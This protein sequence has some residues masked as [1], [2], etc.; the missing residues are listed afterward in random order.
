MSF[1]PPP[2]PPPPPP[3]QRQQ[4]SRNQFPPPPPQN[5]RQQ[6]QQQQQQSFQGRPPPPPPPPQQHSQN[7]FLP[8][9]P[10][11]QNL[12]SV[13]SN[14]PPHHSH[15]G[16]YGQQHQQ[17][18]IQT[19]PPPPPAPMIPPPP[20]PPSLP[21][22]AHTNYNQQHQQQQQH[23]HQGNHNINNI[24]QQQQ[25]QQPVYTSQQSAHQYPQ[26]NSHQQQQ[27][28]KQQPPSCPPLF[29]RPQVDGEINIDAPLP[30]YYPKGCWSNDNPDQNE[31]PPAADSRFISLDDGNAAPDFIRSTM[32]RIPSDRHILRSATG[33][34]E[35]TNHKHDY[36]GLLCTPLAFPSSDH[37]P[38]PSDFVLGSNNIERALLPD[39]GALGR[40]PVDYTTN[41]DAPPRCSRCY[42][43][44]N[45]YWTISKCN[46][47]G[48]SSNSFGQ[49]SSGSTQS[50]YGEK[51]G[52]VDYP[53]QGPYITRTSSG[54]VRPNWIFCVDLTCPKVIDYIDLI[55][56]EIWPAFYHNIVMAHIET[57]QGQHGRPVVLPRVAMA[58][59]C[60]TGIY[61][62]QKSQ[63][64]E[65][66]MVPLSQDGFIVMPDVAH[67]EAFSPLPLSEWSWSFPDEYEDLLSLWNTRIRPVLLPQLI[68]DR[69]KNYHKN[70]S[71]TS[72]SER[73][74]G[75]SMSAGG[76]A[77]EFLVDALEESGGRAVLW[78]WRRPNYGL[79]ALVDRE[80]VSGG[81]NNSHRSSSSNIGG[82]SLYM[83]LQD[84]ITNPKVQ[85]DPN[86]KAAADFYTQLGKRC[87]KAKVALDIVLH[88]NPDVTQSFLD[89]ATLGS[90]CEISGG[91]LIWI[92]KVS[93]ESTEVWKKAIHEELMRPLYLSGWDVIF[94][95]RCSQGLQIRSI[96]S[97]V[98]SL[99]TSS[100]IG[101]D[102][103]LELSV[104]TPETC[105]GVTLEHRI[106]GLPT[107]KDNKFAFVQ[108]ALL[109]TNPWTGDRRIR[110]STL[111]IRVTSE[112]KQVLPAMDFGALAAL[113]LRMNFPHSN[114]SSSSKFS[115]DGISA[116]FDASSPDQKGD[117]LLTDA[118]HD[119]FTACRQVL[120]AHRKLVSKYQTPP[121]GQLLIPESLQLW[122]LFVMS[123]AKSP[124]LRPSVPRRGTGTQSAVPSPRGDERAYYIYHARKV[125]PSS[126]MLLVNPLLFD[127]G[128]SLGL[129]DERP[130]GQ[131]GR[132]IAT[133][134]WK[135][136][137]EPGSSILDPMANLKNSPVVDL[138]SPLPATVSNLAEDGIYLLD[139]CFVVF[140]LIEQGVDDD[141]ILNEDLQSK[142]HT[143][144]QQFQ[145]WSQVAREPTCLRPTASLPVVMVRQKTDVA[146]YQALLRW[147]VLDATSHDKDFGTFCTSLQQQIYKRI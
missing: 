123:A 121:I 22:H 145:L 81:N 46:F 43:Y 27:Q 107:P 63:I 114:Y 108:T 3:Q 124:L 115:L 135:K 127:L 33:D 64:R 21:G 83:P 17:Q 8:P 31:L 38:P 67:D 70:P 87:V 30:M 106:G 37:P 144:V 49:G 90:L 13:G 4:Q 6:Q 1:P 11:P 132:E 42:A 39:S 82:T 75:Y 92:D 110:I 32:Y 100:S 45:P 89:V 88:T 19:R 94:K 117:N 61:I 28:Q 102:D 47:C 68:R 134:Q 93:Y 84:S 142:I 2:P 113:Q 25:Q 53:V 66:E 137:R 86:L 29:T 58:F 128:E 139:T 10:P 109:Y 125:C 111:A 146:Q 119:M 98:G 41:R 14:V 140:V 126:S 56:D 79:G 96:V 35:D 15:P 101:Q 48:R 99:R 131:A 138:P 65:D 104:V 112:P 129:Y 122:P 85:K 95:V 133:Y 59:V 18:T 55:L 54:P 9:P 26:N 24:Q 130:L 103:E 71:S 51:V 57:T 78:T 76:A 62:P 136:L 60:S 91:R 77:L 141:Q 7:Q 69:V 34:S 120:V 52:T 97:S 20:N 23:Q 147:M 40:V 72:H 73:K 74:G 105:L 116:T 80:R 143:A 12:Q 5:P 50:Q 44:V 16:N 36:M 118:R